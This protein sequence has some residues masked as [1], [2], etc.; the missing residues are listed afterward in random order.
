MSFLLAK[1]LFLLVLAA[2]CGAGFAYWWFRRHYEDVTLDYD[3]THL[4]N[5]VT[6]TQDGT[7]QNF[8][9]QD[10]TSSTN[11]FPRTMSRTVNA[12]PNTMMSGVIPKCSIAQNLPVRY[13]PI[14]ISSSTIRTSTATVSAGILRRT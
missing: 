12:L 9:A 2:A 3:S 7:G 4:S 8:Y 14:W 13:K 1:I 5:Q 6:V 10:A 11:Y